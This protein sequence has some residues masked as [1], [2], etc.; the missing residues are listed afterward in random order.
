MFRNTSKTEA[1]LHLQFRGG[2]GQLQWL[3]SQGNPLLS[4]ATGILQSK[5][6]TPNNL[7][8]EDKSMPDLCWWFCISAIIICLAHPRVVM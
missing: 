1:N 5:L 2:V 7:M 8:R 3:Q 6:A 4:F